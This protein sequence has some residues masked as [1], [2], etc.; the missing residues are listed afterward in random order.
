[1][2]VAVHEFG[3]SIGLGHS[4]V[5][6][7]IMYPWFY[8]DQKYK[9]LPEDDRIAIEQLYGPKI[10]WGI[11]DRPTTKTTTTT[12]TTPRSYYPERTINRE[13]EK[14]ERRRRIQAE[15][16]QEERNRKLEAEK[17]LR[18]ESERRRLD[19]IRLEK[20]KKEKREREYQD[21]LNR[22]RNTK[23]PTTTSKFLFGSFKT[24]TKIPH[25]K[26]KTKNNSMNNENYNF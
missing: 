10:K 5:Q 16:A 1:M 20:E 23:P 25:K 3:H 13:Q 4:S 8:G 9:V 11:Y 26:K 2:D 6:S 22:K 7:A 15:R 12:T 14:E 18:E 19:K 24:T 21:H 17:R